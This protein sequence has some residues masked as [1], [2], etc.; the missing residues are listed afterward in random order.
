MLYIVAETI[1]RPPTLDTNRVDNNSANT[2]MR[3]QTMV[4]FL[5]LLTYLHLKFH[6]FRIIQPISVQALICHCNN[7][8]IT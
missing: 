7:V 3:M 6:Y 5:M 4:S 1:Q 8:L 2:M